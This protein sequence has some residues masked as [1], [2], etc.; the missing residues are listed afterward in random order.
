MPMESTKSNIHQPYKV[1]SKGIG[2]SQI[3]PRDYIHQEDIEVDLIRNG[4][5]SSHSLKKTT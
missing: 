2:N 4:G 5:T 1:Q 3:L